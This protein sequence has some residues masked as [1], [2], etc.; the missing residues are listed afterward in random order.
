MVNPP[1]SLG[2][3]LRWVC[4]DDYLRDS[5]ARQKR[6]LKKIMCPLGHHIMSRN[7]WFTYVVAAEVVDGSL[8]QHAVVLELGLAQRR[9]VASNDDELGLARSEALQGCPVVS[10]KQETRELWARRGQHTRLVSKSDLAGLHDKRQLGVDAVGILLAL[11]D[12]HFEWCSEVE[13]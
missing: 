5:T 3:L 7:Y 11:L 9:G 12:G 10:I 1:K 4:R 13:K 6:S 2:R 8:G